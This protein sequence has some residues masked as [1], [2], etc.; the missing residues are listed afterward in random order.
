MGTAVAIY[1]ARVKKIAEDEWEIRGTESTHIEACP[2]ELAT[3]ILGETDLSEDSAENLT[4]TKTVDYAKVKTTPSCVGTLMSVIAPKQIR[5]LTGVYELHNV[6]IHGLS[7]VLQDDD[8]M[9]TWCPKCKSKSPCTAGCEEGL[10]KRWIA[11]VA[12]ADRTGRGEAMAYH[13]ALQ[14]STVLPKEIKTLTSAQFVS[15][16]R[17]ARSYPWSL[18]IIFKRNELK[19][20]NILE[21]KKMT[22]TLS[23]GGLLRAW[24]V[25]VVPEVPSGPGSAFASCSSVTF[26]EGLGVTMVN[27]REVTNAR[28]WLRMLAPV[29]DEETAVPETSAGL[30][31][32]R[33]AR[34]AADPD[35]KDI[36]VITQAGLSSSVQ[37]LMLAPA[38]SIWL[39]LASKRNAGN[40]FVAQGHF[41]VTANEL[42]TLTRYVLASIQKPCGPALTMSQ[43]DTPLKRKAMMESETPNVEREEHDFTEREP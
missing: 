1:Q 25:V 36:Y 12:L 17:M 33:R 37:W 13:E 18:R 23:A 11:K 14:D 16:S 26:D 15:A 5:E 31:V 10:E 34:C 39:V 6:T 29:D 7:S 21:I 41:N 42:T 9:M 4:S 32:K 40:D 30:R 35:D 20:E 3:S 8:L 22:P 38:E 27:Q 2:S 43:H 24:S 28:I 19:D